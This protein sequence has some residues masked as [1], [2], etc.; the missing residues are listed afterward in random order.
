MRRLGVVIG[1]GCNLNCTYCFNATHTT[2]VA[3]RTS[4]RR[5]RMTDESTI[6][7]VVSALSDRKY[8]L[9]VLTGGEPLL[10]RHCLTWLKHLESANIP[11][12]VITNL[13]TLTRRCL[14]SLLQ[15]QRVLLH[16]S[17]GGARAKTHNLHRQR[18][19]ETMENLRI[20]GKIRVPL[21]ISLVLTRECFDEVPEVEEFSRELDCDVHVSPVSG[22]ESSLLAQLPSDAWDRVISRL[23]SP[24]LISEM[25]M[26]KGFFAGSFKLN[27]CEMRTQSHVLNDDGDLFGCFFRTDIRYGNV[28]EDGIGLVLD[29]A[30]STLRLPASCFGA[31]CLGMFTH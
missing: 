4:T 21:A 9:V 20:V 29:N 22:A 11:T 1:N 8:D 16:V 5:L 26:L 17:I 14:A 31:H 18:F 25:I 19:S 28:I 6:A 24:R 3:P 10:Y 30:F 27:Y 12:V 13:A 23:V 2:V 15:C 7:Q